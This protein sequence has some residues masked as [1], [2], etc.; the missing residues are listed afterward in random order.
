MRFEHTEMTSVPPARIWELWADVPSW[1]RWDTE[2]PDSR[3]DGPFALGT[4]GVLTPKA[5]PQSRFRIA[6]LVPNESYAFT[7]TLPLCTLTVRR[8]FTSSEDATAFTHQVSFNGPLRHL[9]G[10]L[11]GR[12]YQRVLPVVMGQ[13]RHLAELRESAMLD[14]ERREVALA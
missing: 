14:P 12:R 5:G 2:L 3:L 1:S 10:A 8:F 4:T 11:L 9:F 7:I 13:L 6:E